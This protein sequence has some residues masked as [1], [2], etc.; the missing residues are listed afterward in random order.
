MKEQFYRLQLCERT[1]NVNKSK[2]VIVDHRS[3][4]VSALSQDTSKIVEYEMKIN[5]YFN[6]KK[7][8]NIDKYAYEALRKR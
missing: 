4:S 5:L 6:L 1:A 3:S 7:C 8:P 2:D